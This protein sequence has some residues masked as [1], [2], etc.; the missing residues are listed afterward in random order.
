MRVEYVCEKCGV[1]SHVYAE[2]AADVWDVAQK[3]RVDH[4]KWSPECNGDVRVLPPP[5]S[6]PPATESVN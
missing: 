5:D 2:D 3:I 6:Q 1:E 4:R